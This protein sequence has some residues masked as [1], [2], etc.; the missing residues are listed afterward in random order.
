MWGPIICPRVGCFW[1]GIFSLRWLKQLFT[2]GVHQRWIC[3]HHLLPSMPALLHL[4]RSTTSGSLGVECL[5]PSLDIS[6]KLCVSSS[7]I[8]SSSSVHVSGRTCQ[9]STFDAGGTML[10][11]GSL[12]SHSSQH[13]GRHFSV[14][15]HHKRSC[16]GCFS[17]P[18]AQG[19]AI[20][21]FNPYAAQR[22][23]AQTGIFFLSLSGSG[24]GNSSV[25]VKD[26]PAVWEGIG[27]LV[28]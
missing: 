3:W 7:S 12:A 19:S 25:Y 2:F 5:Q 11:G 10:D 21:A 15:Y 22:C 28:C 9:R 8:S 16:H 17:R 23:V 26:L 24:R 4:G 13:V 14:L 27:R 6:G 20:S 1:S 18:H